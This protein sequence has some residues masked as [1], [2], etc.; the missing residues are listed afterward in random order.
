[1]DLL[2]FDDPDLYFE[3]AE[4]PDVTRLIALASVR[5]GTKA[6]EQALRDALGLSPDS[7]L[8]LV[9]L[10]R[11]YYYQHNLESARAIGERALGVV[12]EQLGLS[13]DVPPG[14]DELGAAFRRAPAA[15]RFY[16]LTRKAL[17]YLSLRLGDW[18]EARSQLTAVAEFDHHDRL[19]C[20]LLLGYCDQHPANATPSESFNVNSTSA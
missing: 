4:D 3:R 15:A 16:L 17:G 8:V 6:A 14:C 18:G 9:A 2:D 12:S 13:A 1:M 5:Y 19:G 20:K 10:Y 7:L 11:Y